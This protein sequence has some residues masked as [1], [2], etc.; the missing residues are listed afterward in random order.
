M[1]HQ[2]ENKTWDQYNFC[3]TEL[4]KLIGFIFFFSSQKEEEKSVI[5]VLMFF[6]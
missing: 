5:I 6:N 3:K 4:S 1:W 2:E